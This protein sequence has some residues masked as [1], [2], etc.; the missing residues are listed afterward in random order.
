MAT[1]AGVPPVDPIVMGVPTFLAGTPA[2]GI[3]AVTSHGG[4]VAMGDPTFIVT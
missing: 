4:M 1:C 3:G 2:A